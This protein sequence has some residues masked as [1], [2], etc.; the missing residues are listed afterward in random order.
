[1]DSYF[2]TGGIPPLKLL[3]TQF[4]LAEKSRAEGFRFIKRS[5]LEENCPNFHGLKANEE[6]IIGQ[7]PKRKQK[8]TFT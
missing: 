6:R 5:L 3:C 7:L 4:L 8:V 2:A 1:M